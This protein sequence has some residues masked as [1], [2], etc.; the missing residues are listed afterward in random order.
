VHTT[1][2]NLLKAAAVL[3]VDRLAAVHCEAFS[4]NL[5]QIE[6]PKV[7]V[8]SCGGIR[9]S[10]SF[11]ETG[12]RN[13]PFM[14]RDLM[15]QSVFYPFMR[16]AGVTSHYNTISSILTGNWQRLD[17]WGMTPPTSP[18]LFEYLRKRT[19][20]AQDQTW[21]ISS[22]KALSSKIG[23][24][25]VRDFGPAFGA[26]VIFPKQ[27][28]IN[29]V[30]H[31]AAQ[32][33]AVSS[34]DRSTVQPEIEAMLN[35]DNYDGLGWSVSGESASLDIPTLGVMKQA[36]L[37]LVRTNAPVTGDEFTFLVSVEV[38]RR[39]APSMLFVTFSDMEVA[40]FGSY[41]LHLGGIRT[42]DRL[43][44]ELWRQVQE[45]PAYKNKTTLL[46][47]PEFGRDM[48]GSN[49][50]GFFNHRQNSDST[51]TTWMMALGAA[52]DRA[53][54]MENPVEQIDICPS[55]SRIFEL[56][57]LDLPGKQLPGLSI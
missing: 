55:I 34:A 41:S 9:R 52:V 43:V 54:I 53:Q 30:V 8:V 3:L 24:S 28:L 6:A 40:H 44:S 16:N 18:T 37:D 42:V 2:R 10:D 5:P 19:G 36:I 26:N 22:N 35:S 12:I 11:S 23:A 25:S 47:L 48:D 15:P 49:T 4:G 50:N 46:V 21:L 32:G 20:M 51:R 29:T 17:D 45:L 39:F 31:S 1:R 13:I 33:H 38:M 27:L 14:Y 57:N 7:I 56:G